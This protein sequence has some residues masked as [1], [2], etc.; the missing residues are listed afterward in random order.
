[1]DRKNFIKKA[2]MISMGTTLAGGIRPVVKPRKR[3]KIN[4]DDREYWLK[5]VEQLSEPV[6]FN[7][8]QEK[9]KEVMP[10]E[11]RPGFDSKYRRNYTYL[12]AF[13]RL[14]TGIAPWLELGKDN[15]QEGKLRSKYID[16][17]QQSMSVAANPNSPDFLNFNKGKQPLVD[18]AFLA[19]AM[20]KAPTV[21][22]EELDS[23]TKENLI[24]ALKSSREIIPSYSNWVL[25]TAMV[26]AALMKFDK[27]HDEVRIHFAVKA[28]LDWYLGDGMYG[29]GPSFHCDY[30]NSFVIQ[31]FML[32]IIEVMMEKHESYENHYK[33]NLAYSKR[34]AE[35]LHRSIAPDGSYP[36]IGRSICY[37]YGAFQLLAQIAWM[38]ELPENISPAQV[39]NSLTKAI[40]KINEAPGTYDENGWLTLG[41]YGHQPHLAEVYVTTGSLYLCSGA[42]LPLGLPADDE[43]W[44]APAEATIPEKIW[45]GEDMERDQ[46]LRL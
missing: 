20:I 29:D 34:Y 36:P 2:G 40:K 11:S 6:L 13:G 38:K 14:L 44:T 17:A 3:E 30:Y 16:L 1:M 9:L 42:L 28:V 12:E 24:T 23:K 4:T 25:F 32:S 10:V 19:H 43:F 21:L 45:S 46:H 37:R 31:P 35:I 7:L 41:L 5:V 8:S 18:A 27:G 39:R 15:T 33:T 22:W 26:E